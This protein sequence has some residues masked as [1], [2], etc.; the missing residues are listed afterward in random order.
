[1]FQTTNQL[2]ISNHVG[3]SLGQI[4]TGSNPPVPSAAS[5]FCLTSSLNDAPL[6]VMLPPGVRFRAFGCGFPSRNGPPVVFCAPN[7]TADIHI[8]YP[9]TLGDILHASLRSCVSI[10]SKKHH[11]QSYQTI[12]NRGIPSQHNMGTVLW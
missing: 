9:T 3:S 6:R 2:I 11:A 8:V 12:P 10:C 1:M 7:F 5:L 4:I